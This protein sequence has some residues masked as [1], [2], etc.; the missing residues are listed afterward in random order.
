MSAI[1]AAPKMPT[2]RD[3]ALAKPAQKAKPQNQVQP[4]E[5]PKPH[6]PPVASTR[7]YRASRDRQIPLVFYIRDREPI[8]GIVVDALQF[9]LLVKDTSTGKH[10]ILLKH[11]IDWVEFDP[12]LLS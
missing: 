10:L 1:I 12:G 6:H 3:L 7:I 2:I 8:T 9:D 5:P 4:T 11:A